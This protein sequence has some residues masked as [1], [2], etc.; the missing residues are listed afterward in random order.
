MR[1]ILPVLLLLP[2]LSSAQTARL[3]EPVPSA[4][5]QMFEQL[6]AGDW[7]NWIPKAEALDYLSRYD[8]PNAK[9]AVQKILDDKN[10]NNRWLRGQAVIAMARIHPAGAAALAKSH[11][12]DPHVEVRAAVAQVCADLTKAQA[13][14]ILEKL[15]AD[16]TPAIQFA[17]LASY[18]QHHGEQAWSKA[19]TIT[20]KIPDGAIQPAAR[21]L[22]WIGN[23]PAL[24]RLREHIAQ[25][26]HVHEILTGLKGV[27][28]PALASVYMDLLASSSDMTLLAG[29]W[30][31]LKEFENKAIVT[32]CQSA[33][34]S[35]DQK[36]I[37]AVS[38]LIASYLRE[39]ALGDTLKKALEK[40]EDLATRKLGLTALSC[41]E[42]DRFS[43]YFISHL[44][45]K[46]PQV[47]A[48]ACIV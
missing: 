26:K 19:E 6:E 18:A 35:G 22:A 21:A 16:K 46:D 38:R 29:V 17:A 1:F 41:V 25:G 37:Q 15:F 7:R 27:T 43:D 44:G 42:A 32:A 31:Q 33:L 11:A 36:K 9:P 48:T 13:T 28:N 8:V 39:P 45:H 20:A 47:R 23:D 14:P 30:A 10:A 24:A 5:A 12:E 3:P 2:A 40:S 4:A 34:E